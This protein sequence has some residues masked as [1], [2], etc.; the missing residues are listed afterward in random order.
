MSNGD[1]AVGPVARGPHRALRFDHV[2]LSVAELERS[3]RFYAEV[4]GFDRVEDAFELPDHEIRG[5]VLVNPVG[6]RIELFE[7]RGSK[8]GR[9]GHPT[10]GALTQGWFQ[11]ALAVADAETAFADAVAAGATPLL[12]P[13][14]APDGRSRVAF[15]GDPDGN[16]IEFLQ[17]PAW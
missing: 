11:F 2:G 8:P 10:D 13:R 9:L 3:R 7:R 16:L 15:I 17:R 12:S 1:G 4:L 5:L 14:V 6:V